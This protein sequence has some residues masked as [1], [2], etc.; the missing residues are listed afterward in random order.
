MPSPT[1]DLASGVKRERN[2]AR[3]Y[4]EG[5]TRPPGREGE[6]EGRK[7]QKAT[8]RS[9]IVLYYLSTPGW[10][11]SFHDHSRWRIIDEEE[12]DIIGTEEVCADATAG[13]ITVSLEQQ[14]NSVI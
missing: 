4:N 12:E 5:H 14:H 3:S 8:A 7:E 13:A 2:G 10:K 11:A 6:P 9:W 1:P